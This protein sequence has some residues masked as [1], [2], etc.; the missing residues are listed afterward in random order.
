[1]D[2]WDRIPSLAPVGSLSKEKPGL[3]GVGAGLG[4]LRRDFRRDLRRSSMVGIFDGILT[5]QKRRKG[6][7]FSPVMTTDD[8]TNLSPESD[9][10]RNS[11]T[12]TTMTTTKRSAPR[13]EP[14]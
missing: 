14:G 8:T 2:R 7:S 6:T 9:S 13:S 4:L 3:V 5:A 10:Q 11:D 1:M 12:T